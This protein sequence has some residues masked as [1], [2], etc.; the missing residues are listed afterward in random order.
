MKR[1]R[2]SMEIGF[3][4]AGRVGTAL[5]REVVALGYQ[6]AGIAD[7]SPARARAAC[8]SAGMPGRC[9]AAAKVASLSRVLFLTVPDREIGR[10]FVRIRARVR[11]GTIVAHTSGFF[12]SEV[13]A[14]A[15]RSG[16]E[17]LAFHPALAFPEDGRVCGEDTGKCCFAIDGSRAGAAFGRRLAKQMGGECIIVRG[18]DRPLYH[19][20]C[21]FATN[22]QH[23]L[24]ASA[25]RIAEEL[26]VKD[27]QARGLLDTLMRA[28]FE[29]LVAAGAGP[30]LTGPVRRG[31]I[32]T[33]TGHLEALKQRV[34][35]LVPLYSELT[36]EL[37]RL[38]LEQGE[39]GRKGRE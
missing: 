32:E 38:S 13:F 22:F 30:G 37:I 26:E 33:V 34:P 12:G 25:E 27:E 20:M 9:A 2:V 35:G 36:R 8:R 3:I 7:R 1:A 6:L 4:G 15:K 17:T 18:P 24:R 19:A 5:A 14:D 28:G 39:Q 11:P 21:V 10:V 29:N 31:D 23:A 16:L